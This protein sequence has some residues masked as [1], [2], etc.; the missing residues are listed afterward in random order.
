MITLT[1]LELANPAFQD[2]VQVIWDCPM[3]D[4]HTSYSAH[5]IQS[6]IAVVE[7]EIAHFRKNLTQKHGKKDEHGKLINDERGYIVFDTPEQHKAFEAEFTEK[8]K[9]RKIELKVNK[10]DFEKIVNV[11]G[12]T[13]SMWQYLMP[14]I[15][16]LPE[17][18]APCEES[19]T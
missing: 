18:T 12:I 16:N 5:R 13:P 14:I 7:K 10:I 1:W 11:R 8:F 9:T 6:G 3:L 4:G 19:V 2:A 15:D 17:A